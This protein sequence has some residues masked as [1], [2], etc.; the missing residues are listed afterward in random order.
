MTL[1]PR[2]LAKAAESQHKQNNEKRKTSSQILPKSKVEG[3]HLRRLLQTTCCLWR[4][5]PDWTFHNSR[6]LLSTFRVPPRDLARV[7][8]EA[9]HFL[10]FSLFRY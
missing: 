3:L 4:P 2:G 5:S 9:T 1:Q 10:M 7:S 8:L 6:W